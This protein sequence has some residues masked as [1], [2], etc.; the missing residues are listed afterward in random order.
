MT[1]WAHGSVDAAEDVFEVSNVVVDVTDE[2]ATLARKKALQEGSHIAFQR[3]LR[4]LTLA[5]DRERLPRLD[6]QE[7]SGFVRDFGVSDEKTASKRYLAKLSYRFRR[8]EVRNLLKSFNLQFAETRSKPVLILPVYQSAGAIALWDDPNPWRDAWSRSAEV[9]GLVPQLKPAGD[10]ADVGSIGPEQAIQGDRERL[11]AIADRY[12]TGDVIVAYGQLRL[13]AAVAR[14]RLEV[15]V[16]RYGRDPEPLTQN[17]QFRQSETESV[18]QLLNRAVTGVADHIENQWKEENLLKLNRPNIAAVA[19]PITGLKDWLMVNERLKG[20]ALVRQAELV[21]LSLDEAR[22]NL[23]YA[24]E[25][26]QLQVALRQADLT[27]VREDG[28]WVI[29]LANLEQTA[30]PER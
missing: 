17:L 5:R 19:V 30:K 4:R 6:Q 24:G 29:Y 9:E 21:L 25:P 8:D 22:V 28:E 16:T 27:M 1:T 12:G 14:Q 15:F 7:I 2:S 10:L 20:V 13:D 11:Q 23:H 18:D 3:L 26:E